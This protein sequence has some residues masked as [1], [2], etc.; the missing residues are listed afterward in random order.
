MA[1]DHSVVYVETDPGRF[2]LRTVALGLILETEAIILDGLEA[3]EDVA[4]SGNFLIDS[5]MQ[6]AGK[7]SLI[8]P[9]RAGPSHGDSRNRNEPLRF[10]EIR[11]VNVPDDA[12]GKLEELFLAYFRIQQSLA[13]DEVPAAD[14]ALALNQLAQQL[15]VDPAIPDSAQIQLAAITRH[16]EHIHPLGTRQSAPR[17]LP[18]HQFTR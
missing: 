9:K 7:P 1:G 8:D 17:F 11:V 4:T 15:K 6:L 18:F 2:E 12:G 3:G 13:T 10:A 5:Q 16:S 14:D